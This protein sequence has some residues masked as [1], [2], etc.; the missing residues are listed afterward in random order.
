MFESA[1]RDQRVDA[2]LGRGSDVVFG[3]VAG[4]GEDLA[5]SGPAVR[6][7]LVERRSLQGTG[8]PADA[9]AARLCREGGTSASIGLCCRAA[10]W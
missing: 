10:R 6:F 9:L 8:P 7:G 3:E 1:R 2:P 5:G 4:I